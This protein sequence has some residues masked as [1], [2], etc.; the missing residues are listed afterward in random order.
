M[1]PTISHAEEVEKLLE[2]DP[3]HLRAYESSDLGCPLKFEL[4]RSGADLKKTEINA[5][6]GLVEKTAG[7][8]YRASSIGWNPRKKK[9]EMTDPEMMYLLEIKPE[10]CDI[11]KVIGFISFMFTNDDPPHL[12]RDVVYIY[13]V[14]LDDHLRG[15][16]LGSN[17]IQFVENVASHCG[18]SKTMLTVFTANKGARA[19]YERL[20]YGKDECSPKPRMTR[21]KVIESDYMIMSKELP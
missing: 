10:N 21:R 11:G 8:D 6:I 13:E 17:L 14:H 1:S 15:R 7:H 3:T 9:E 19:L 2:H 20:G 4:V 12:D 16:G 18:I 5:C